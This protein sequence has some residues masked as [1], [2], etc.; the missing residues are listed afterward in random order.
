MPWAVM[1]RV[2]LCTICMSVWRREART[3]VIIDTCVQGALDNFLAKLVQQLMQLYS[4]QTSEAIAELNR[5]NEDGMEAL[6][7]GLQHLSKRMKE[8]DRA[9]MQ[10]EQDALQRGV[11]ATQGN[12]QLLEKALATII[13]KFQVLQVMVERSH[14]ELGRAEAGQARLLVDLGCVRW[15]VQQNRK[16][17]S[18]EHMTLTRDCLI[19]HALHAYIV[20]C[21]A[22][23]S[24]N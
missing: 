1:G 18:L 16:V 23:A 20:I 8:S 12:R 17:V 11:E 2:C 24:G 9:R 3:R 10:A 21:V 5:N 14:Q 15:H 22:D 4:D 7:G 19:E 6:G 13:D